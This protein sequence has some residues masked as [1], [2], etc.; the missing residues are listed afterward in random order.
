MNPPGHM[1]PE[2]LILRTPY[3]F[4]QGARKQGGGENS[5]VPN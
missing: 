4:K 3:P 2:M 5:Y 1:K